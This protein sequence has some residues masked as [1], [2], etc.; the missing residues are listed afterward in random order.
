MKTCQNCKKIINSKDHIS[1][2]KKLYGLKITKFLCLACMADHAGCE[3][4][5]LLVKIEELKESGCKIFER[6]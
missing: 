2:N 6:I 4:E 3:V 1:L 5:D